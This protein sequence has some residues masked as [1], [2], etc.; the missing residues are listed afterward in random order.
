MRQYQSGSQST[1]FY[2]A[3]TFDIRG[4][5]KAQ[6]FG[7]PLDGRVRQH[8]A[9]PCKVRKSR[10]LLWPT[11][12]NLAEL[13]FA[14]RAW[15]RWNPTGRAASRTFAIGIG[16]DLV[17]GREVGS[18]DCEGCAPALYDCALCVFEA[19]EHVLGERSQKGRLVDA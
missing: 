1:A 4:A 18:V 14:D 3:L 17:V 9:E 5:Q 8:R 6:P 19:T 7:H 10:G 16:W 13:G 12:D 2:K 15:E 11:A